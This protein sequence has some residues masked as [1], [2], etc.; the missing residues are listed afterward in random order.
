MGT[1]TNTFACFA[2]SSLPFLTMSMTSCA[3]EAT[4]SDSV[5]RPYMRFPFDLK[6]GDTAVASKAR[7]NGPL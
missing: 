5:A 7:R 4:T 3:E 2:F 6:D 1:K